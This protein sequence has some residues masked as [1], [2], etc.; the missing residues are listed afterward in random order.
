MVTRTTYV[1]LHVIREKNIEG[2]KI[3]LLAFSPIEEKDSQNAETRFE[4]IDFQ[5]TE[6]F[7]GCLDCIS[8]II[9][10][11]CNLNKALF[12]KFSA[13]FMDCH[14]HRLSLATGDI[15]K[16]CSAVT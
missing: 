1:N 9:G 16:P 14:S 8:T 3:I 11:N 12:Q 10:D 7:C 2:F 5:I 13:R 4:C 15:M 6:V